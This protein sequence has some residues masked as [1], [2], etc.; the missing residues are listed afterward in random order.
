MVDKDGGIYAGYVGLS[1]R[2]RQVG[3]SGFVQSSGGAAVEL[4]PRRDG[5]AVEPRTPGRPP[6]PFGGVTIVGGER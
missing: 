1:N 2:A 5:L 4:I 6:G 3:C